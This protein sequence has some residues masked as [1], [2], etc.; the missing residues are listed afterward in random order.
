MSKAS[1]KA[2]SPNKDSFVIGYRTFL[3]SK[4][5]KR[6][7]NRVFK[8]NGKFC[9]IC[10]SIENLSIHHPYYSKRPA[11]ERNADLVVVCRYHH[12]EIHNFAINENVKLK[13]AHIVYKQLLALE[14]KYHLW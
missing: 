1:Y 4:K 11:K 9:F 7:R 3:E 6:K 14:G 2:Y 8:I 12:L 10:G 13:E 5:W